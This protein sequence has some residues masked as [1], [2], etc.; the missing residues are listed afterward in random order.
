MNPHIQAF[1]HQPT[2]TV[3]YLV[4]D[5][6]SKAGAVIDPVLDFDEKSGRTGTAFADSILQ[7]AAEQNVNI[8]WVL[9]THAHADHL[10][11]AQHIKRKTGARIAIGAEIVKVQATFKALFNAKELP[12]DGSQ[13]DRLVRDGECIAL[14]GNGI[15]GAA[16]AR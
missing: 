10:S 8:V 14:G 4:F 15:R 12:A 7:A 13:F 2:F 9:E 6:A 16:Y 1:F 5:P 11:A 3:S